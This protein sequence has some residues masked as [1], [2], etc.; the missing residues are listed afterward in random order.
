LLN[1]PIQNFAIGGAKADNSNT[2][3]GLPGFTFEVS[4]FL[5]IGPQ[6]PAF[7]AYGP[8]FGPNDL[9]TV[10]IGGNDAR[11]YQQLGGS[12]AGA[13]TAAA[14]AIA[15]ATNNLDLLVGAGAQ[16]ISFL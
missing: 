10:S 2:Q 8:V 6:V 5:G 14:T 12:L 3:A 11:Q 1:V 9:V 16:N 4:N 7:P 13:P 15:N